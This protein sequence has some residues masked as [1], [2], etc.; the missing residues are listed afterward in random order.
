MKT[1]VQCK[2]ERIS[3]KKMKKKKKFDVEHFHSEADVG[4]AFLFLQKL[5]R[6]QNRYNFVSNG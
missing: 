5:L 4:R 3:E 2:K 1:F 6:R